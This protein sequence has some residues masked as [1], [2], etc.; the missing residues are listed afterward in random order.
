MKCLLPVGA[1]L[2]ERELL[3]SDKEHICRAESMDKAT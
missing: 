2:F 3:T 1:A